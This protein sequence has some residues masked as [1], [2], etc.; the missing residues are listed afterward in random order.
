M[1]IKLLAVLV[2]CLVMTATKKAFSQI[3][4]QDSLALV[5]LYNSTDGQNW[6]NKTNWLTSAP[7]SQWYGVGVSS[8]RVLWITLGQNKLKGTLPSTLQ[9]LSALIALHLPGNQL[10]GNIPVEIGSL[11]QVSNLD[12]SFNHFSGTVPASLTN[13][14]SWA[15]INLV[16]NKLTFSGMELLSKFPSAFYEP[17]AD[18]PLQRTGNVLSVDAGGSVAKNTYKWYKDNLLVATTFGNPY[19]T[20]TSEGAYSV[21]VTNDVATRLTLYSIANTHSIDSV[22]L[23]SF[24]R[25]TNGASWTDNENWLSGPVA[26]WQGVTVRFGH[27][28]ELRLPTNNLTGTIPG[29]LGNLNQLT[30]LDLSNNNLSGTIPSTSLLVNLNRLDLRKNQ[31]TGSIPSTTIGSAINLKAIDLSSNQLTGSIP[32][33]IGNLTSLT[34]INLSSN[35]LSGVVPSSIGNCVSLSSFEAMNNLL[36]GS[37]PGSFAKLPN[38]TV[39]HLSNNQL[40]GSIPDSVCLIKKLVRFE[41]GFNQFAGKIPDSIGTLLSLISLVLNDNQLIGPLPSMNKLRTNLLLQNNRFTFDGMETLPPK[42]ELRKYSPQAKILLHKNENQISVSAGGT[43]ANNTYKL[44][45]DGT[46]VSQHIADSVFSIATPGSYYVTVGNS[47]ATE[48]TLFSDTIEYKEAINCAGN[49]SATAATV[50]AECGWGEPGRATI[51][52][53][54]GNGG[55]LYSLDSISYQ[56]SNVFNLDPGTYRVVAKDNGGCVAVTNFVI[57]EK[58]SSITAAIS[59][60]VIACN[61]NSITVTITP[62]TGSLPYEYSLNSS[63]FQP[64]NRFPN[65]TAGYYTLT[66][67]D[68]MQCSKMF[69]F[70]IVTAT[71]PSLVINN[72]IAVCAPLTVDLTASSVTAGSQAGLQLSYWTNAEATNALNNP[73]SV[74]LSG[75]YF[76]KAISTNGCFSIKPVTVTIL[77]LPTIPVIT[78]NGSDIFCEG[79]SVMLNSSQG[80]NY[81]WYRNNS[82]IVGATNQSYT[83]ALSGNYEVRT[84]N[85][86]ATSTSNIITITVTPIPSI[87]AAGATSFC[88][89][90][91]VTL[92]SSA[93]IANQWYKNGIAITNATSQNYIATESGDYTVKVSNGSCTTTAS[94][95]IIVKVNQTP[96]APVIS[97][98]GNNL[99]SSEAL[100]NKWYNNGTIIGGATNQTYE[101]TTPGVYTATAALNSC[102]SVSSNAIT[103]S[104]VNTSSSLDSNV[105]TGPN[106]ANNFLNIRYSGTSPS[107]IV[108]LSDLSGRVLVTVE[109]FDKNY[110][111]DMR[112]YRPG[113]YVLAITTPDNGDRI[114]RLIVKQ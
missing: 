14:P 106:P 54:G 60:T 98:S 35:Q 23:L 43:L 24:Y 48:L 46:L 75:T 11:T 90:L 64:S 37:I 41:V 95:I 61:N 40:S 4:A 99:V 50:D 69:N 1:R 38:F 21:V 17:Q 111:L 10:F 114:Q 72:L 44:F 55:I 110:L 67:R 31:L 77:D 57:G 2:F 9:N 107:F 78:S 73:S 96:A 32:E 8:S 88:Q 5:S 71:T 34:N 30:V 15:T 20:I 27:V 105:K 108:V 68:S 26:T 70:S 18:I 56:F 94:N 19:Y 51:T 66:V 33:N 93:A 83:A 89:G 104:S 82:L 49:F 45:K 6:L 101:V 65:L 36:K 102:T 80:G 112:S 53:T 42:V 52:T 47:I 81:Q 109:V 16:Y 59:D 25:L 100:G 113:Y 92:N 3:N 86:C 97:Q 103:I 74:A 22:T 12:L 85:S 28:I 63:P 62:S 91:N 79:G 39:L 7:L 29:V 13:L 58:P 84:S 76:I 87:N